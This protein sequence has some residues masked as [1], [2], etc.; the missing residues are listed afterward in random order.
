MWPFY[1]IPCALLALVVGPRW[2]TLAAFM[3]AISATLFSD[4][5][6]RSGHEG[7]FLVLWNLAMRF[8]VFEVPV[9]LLARMR[10]EIETHDTSGPGN[11]QASV[12]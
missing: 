7:P 10:S 1:L 4:P 5:G 3:C 12:T 6:P 2:G 9:L 8:L 11:A